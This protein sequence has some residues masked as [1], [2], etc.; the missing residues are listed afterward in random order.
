M[1][2]LK[3]QKGQTLI[4]AL[5][6]LSIA[7]AVVGAITVVVISSLNNATFTRNQNQ[8]TQ[9]AQEGIE[10]VK[11]VS[12]SES[13]PNFKALPGDTYCLDKSN[14]QL[15][16]PLTNPGTGGCGFNVASIFSREVN[17]DHNNSD[18]QEGC[19]GNTKVTVKVKWSDNKCQDASGPFCHEVALTSCLS[20]YNPSKSEGSSI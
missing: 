14:T 10:I 13:S 7:V 20:D 4:E 11:R 5:V 2:N 19:G 17:I 3:N 15:D 12:L 1:L 16:E 8:A 9:Y 6:S 18:P